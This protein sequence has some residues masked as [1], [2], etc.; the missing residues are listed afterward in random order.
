MN[1]THSR[2]HSNCI[3]TLSLRVL[4]THTLS[5]LKKVFKTLSESFVITVMTKFK[6]NSH[7][8]V[9]IEQ[10]YGEISGRE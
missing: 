2:T 5:L 9:V 4:N 3:H 8:Y 1:D 10:W 6:K 7:A